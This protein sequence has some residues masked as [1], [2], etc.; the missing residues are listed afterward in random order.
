[1]RRLHI[2]IPFVLKQFVKD[3]IVI[4]DNHCDNKYYKH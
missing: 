3:M 2:S 4:S 1:M